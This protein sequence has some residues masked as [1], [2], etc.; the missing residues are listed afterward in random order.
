MGKRESGAEGAGTRSPGLATLVGVAV[1]LLFALAGWRGVA[2]IDR[3]LGKTL[4]KVGSRFDR[5]ATRT[6]QVPGPRRGPD[7]GRV[8]SIRTDGSP[9]RG[10]VAAPV[11]IVEFSDF[12]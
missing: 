1:G 2:R 8:Y 9:V 6:E 5:V 4:G 12:Q 7:A 11:T 10:N 3:G